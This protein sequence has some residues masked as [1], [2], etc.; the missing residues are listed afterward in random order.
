M[1]KIQNFNTKRSTICL[2]AYKVTKDSILNWLSF[3]S[4][5]F[6]SSS[7]PGA[8]INIRLS[9]NKKTGYKYLLVFR[10]ILVYPQLVPS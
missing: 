4:H 10:H 9:E 3:F 1:L 8:E 7:P 6:I 2:G 5:P